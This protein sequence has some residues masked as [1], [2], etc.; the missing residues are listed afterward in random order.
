MRSKYHEYFIKGLLLLLLCLM[1]TSVSATRPNN[2]I[3]PL[4][5]YFAFGEGGTITKGLHNQSFVSED[6]MKIHEVTSVQDAYKFRFIFKTPKDPFEMLSLR[7]RLLFNYNTSNFICWGG[8]HNITISV[9]PFELATVEGENNSVH[10]V[11]ARELYC[12]RDIQFKLNTSAFHE[13]EYFELAISSWNATESLKGVQF[14]QIRFHVAPSSLFTNYL[15]LTTFSSIGLFGFTIVHP[16]RFSN[17]ITVFFTVIFVIMPLAVITQV[18]N[19]LGSLPP[20]KEKGVTRFTFFNRV[21]ERRDLGNGLFSLQMVKDLSTAFELQALSGTGAQIV[22]PV[23]EKVDK[24]DIPN[25]T[26]HI[27][28]AFSE[29]TISTEEAT[30][31]SSRTSSLSATSLPRFTFGDITGSPTWWNSSYTYVKQFTITA[32]SSAL[33]TN[34]TIQLNMSTDS[35]V[36]ASKMRADCKDLRIAYWGGSSWTELDRVVLNNNTQKTA[37]FFRLQNDISASGSDTNYAIYYG[38]RSGHPGN[39][40]SDTS[41]IFIDYD[42]FSSGN[43]NNYNPSSSWSATTDSGKPINIGWWTNDNIATGSSVAD[44]VLNRTNLMTNNS[45][46]LVLLRTTTSITSYIGLRSNGSTPTDRITLAH[47]TSHLAIQR[48]NES[49]PWLFATYAEGFSTSE[50]Y[51]YKYQIV[52]KTLKGMNWLV[53][54][55]EPSNWNLSATRNEIPDDGHLI[56]YASSNGMRIGM[57]AVMAAVSSPPSITIASE[58]EEMVKITDIT[59][60]PDYDYD[61]GSRFWKNNDGVYE[62]NFTITI[63]A[64]WNV[65]GAAY[66]GE[67][68]IGYSSDN[69]S[70][71]STSGLVIKVDEDPS[72]GNIIERNGITVGSAV[73]YNGFGSKVYLDPGLTFYNIGWDNEAPTTTFSSIVED[74]PH[75]FL[76]YPGSGQTVYFSDGMAGIDQLFTVTVTADDAAGAGV[77]GVFMS[78]WDD[79][80]DTNITTGPNYARQYSTDS[81]ET[82]GSINLYTYDNVGNFDPSPVVITMTE[83]TTNPTTTFSSIV[84]DTP[85]DFLYYPGSGQTVYFSDGMAGTDQLFTVTVTADDAAGAGVYGVFMSAWDDDSD[86]NITTGP[87]YARQYSTDSSET[88]GSI[89][90]YTYDNVGNFDPSPVVITMTEDTTDPTTTFS[91]IVEDTPH[92]FLYYPGSGTTV[93]FSD[94]MAG[95]DQLFTVT[96]TADDAAGAGVYAVFMST[97]DD[98]S[99]INITTG[100]NYARQYSTDSSETSGT[101]NLYAYDNVGNFDPSP[102]VITMTEDT[103]NPTTTFSSIVEETPHDFLYYPG[104]GQTIYFSDDMAGT[105]Q[106]FTVTVTAGDTGGAGLYGVRMSTWDDDSDTYITTGPNYARQYSTDSSET[107]GTINLYAYD[108]VGNFDPSPVVITMTEDTIAP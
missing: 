13:E 3:Y 89:N 43:L 12:G 83:D 54:N 1:I 8:L 27:D 44:G 68:N 65:S 20:Q 26:E 85:H 39:P 66:P 32:G 11:N 50:W 9:F 105:D 60:T 29:E 95:T 107:S 49:G 87:N 28:T 5:N 40:P 94:G 78:A 34:Y 79:E 84:E 80:L 59:I 102:V 77:Y 101:I 75:D 18:Q 56:F 14:E 88:S 108:N 25:R 38:I 16:Q 61:D 86:I 76:Y 58:Q 21:Y 74:T 106:L 69:T 45:Q 98:D 33:Y 71:G 51:F 104:S 92:D 62:D 2:S 31:S 72:V 90:L 24:E 42:D 57:W 96:V 91:S 23:F 67:V 7:V 17:I 100:P 37:V 103:T 22:Y 99:D 48:Y 63:T 6:G 64:V 52:E 15:L 10:V 47:N 53:G 30:I 73:P 35:L 4:Y 36:S 93:Y 19:I 41:K 55:S 46:I 81:S 82:S 97:W 70:Y